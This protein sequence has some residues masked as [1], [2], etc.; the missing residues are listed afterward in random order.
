MSS[1]IKDLE[2]TLWA[3]ADKMRGGISVTNYKF[4]IL[5]LIFLKYISDSFEEQY[6][7]LR[8]EGLGFEED[9]DAY[10]Q[11]NIFFVPEEARWGYIVKHAKDY[12]IGEI[13]DKAL[14]SIEKE[15]PTLKG[16][17]FKVYNDPD[18]RNV[19]LGEIIDLFTNIKIGTKEATEKDL[20]GRIYEY[21]L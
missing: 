21:F 19:N 9:R 15:N 5:G 7:K 4:L 14:D 2:K 18:N 11:D 1:N 3:A 17:L 10:V 6:E 16:V 20:L 12:N 8:A 13:L